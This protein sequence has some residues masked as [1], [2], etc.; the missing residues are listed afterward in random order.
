MGIRPRSPELELADFQRPPADEGLSLTQLPPELSSTLARGDDPYALAPDDARVEPSG[1]ADAAIS[2]EQDDAAVS[3]KGILEAMLFV[4]H[5]S[6]EP[7]TSRYVAALMRGVR[8]A[9]VD[10]WIRELNADY[11]SAG[12]PYHIVPEEHGY[13]LGLRAEF[14]G[15][16]AAFQGKVREARLS[17]AA[18]D[19]LAVVAYHQP[20]E[21]RRIQELCEAATGGLLAQ[22]VRRELLSVERPAA[23][24]D[25]SYRTTERFLTLFGLDS[26]AELPRSL[27]LE[28]PPAG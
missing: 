13:R 12:C 4:G 10:E 8:A 27:D 14:S 18:I 20:V 16:Q 1:S 26:L 2:S 17:Q 6:N 9:E 22:L 21:R 28:A 15:L 25:A 3:P 5:P 19:V 23:G 11:E 24:Q 7:L